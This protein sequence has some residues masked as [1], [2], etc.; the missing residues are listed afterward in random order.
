MPIKEHAYKVV[1]AIA[2]AV[3]IDVIIHNE[4]ATLIMHDNI[5]EI[6]IALMGFCCFFCFITC[7]IALTIDATQDMMTGEMSSMI[8]N[9]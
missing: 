2:M 8:F 3:D 9:E 4:S 5:D 7:N 1:N 6:I